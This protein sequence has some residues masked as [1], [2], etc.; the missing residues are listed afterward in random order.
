MSQVA[1]TQTVLPPG[2]GSRVKPVFG[3]EVRDGRETIRV[4]C[5]SRLSSSFGQCDRHE[6]KQA[7]VPVAGQ[8]T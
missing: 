5:H 1:S 7:R 6:A 4:G 3:D 2:M 8:K